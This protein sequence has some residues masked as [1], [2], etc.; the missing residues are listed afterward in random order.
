MYTLLLFPF[1][2]SKSIKCITALQPIDLSQSKDGNLPPENILF[3]RACA[4]V[5][6]EC[7]W[8]MDRAVSSSSHISDLPLGHV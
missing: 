6:G 4:P 5:S 7:R 2:L 1:T 8:L 3:Y